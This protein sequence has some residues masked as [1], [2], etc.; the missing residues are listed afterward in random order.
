M[1]KVLITGATGFVGQHLT[2]YLSAQNEFQ[3]FG[4]SLTDA[5]KNDKIQIEK[6]DL[7]SFGDVQNLIDKILPD[8][9]Y[10]L[11]AL[12]SPASSFDDSKQVVLGNIEVQLNILD[13]VRKNEMNPRVLIIS[14]GEIYGL[15]DSSQLPIDEK[16][17]MN[18]NNPYAVSKIAQDYL[19]LQYAL[20]YKMDIIRVRPFNHTGPGQSP[21]FAIPAFAKQIAAIEKG[22]QEP[23]LKVGSLNA[24]RDFTD[25]RDIV[26]GYALIMEKGQSREAYNI[27]SG[28]SYS[29][30]KLLDMLLGF[31]K[32]QIDIE[33]DPVKMRPSDIEDIYCNFD[34]LN[35]LT[36]WKPEIEIEKT[37]KD[38]LDYYRNID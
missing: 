16:A 35:S 25:V 29:I 3:L 13:A 6:I 9:I 11:A 15:V 18:P 28:K 7:T 14:S 36:G 17:E 38:T 33:E 37:L 8:Q 26:K 19:G 1:K 31:S 12:T 2:E 27:G 32:K 21:A 20:S 4:T 34:K 22:G 5:E 10:H 23:I 24:K 30:K